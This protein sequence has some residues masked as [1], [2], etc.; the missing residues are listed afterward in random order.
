M[1]KPTVGEYFRKRQLLNQLSEELESLE[2]SEAL[3]HRI[4]LEYDIK[5]ILSQ[6]ELTP[7]DLIEAVVALY[8]EELSSELR[9]SQAKPSD[10][11]ETSATVHATTAEGG[12]MAPPQSRPAS[13]TRPPEPVTRRRMK[14]YR[15]PHTG[16]VVHTR[17]ANHRTLNLWRQKYGR[18][19]VDSWWEFVDESDEAEHASD[20]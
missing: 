16:E 6:Y 10:A 8:P 18:D 9:G 14:R 13:S 3:K 5:A 11:T 19:M 4:N 17:G 7:R 2:E 12:T 20:S 1:T 15:N